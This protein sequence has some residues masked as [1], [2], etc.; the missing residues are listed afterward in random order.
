MNA[1]RVPGTST[2]ANSSIPTA[3]SVGIKSRS[4][5]RR[6]LPSSST[7]RAR[8]RRSRIASR[9]AARPA[10]HVRRCCSRRQASSPHVRW[11]PP[12]RG[13]GRNHLWQTEQGFFFTSSWRSTC[14]RFR[15]RAV[16]QF[17][18]AHPGLI[19]PAVKL[20]EDDSSWGSCDTPRCHDGG[21]MPASSPTYDRFGPPTGCRRVAGVSQWGEDDSSWPGCDSGGAAFC[22]EGDPTAPSGVSRAEG[23]RGGSRRRSRDMK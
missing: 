1:S 10:A 2:R 19:W 13:C 18:S 16:D 7:S 3:T 22:S 11:R 15:A 6:S 17:S 21:R 9:L 8:R 4:T 14:R 20:G 23:S 12:S 5:S